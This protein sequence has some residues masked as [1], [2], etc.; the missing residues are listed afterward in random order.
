MC[1]LVVNQTLGVKSKK[2]HNTVQE[3]GGEKETQKSRVMHR[4]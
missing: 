4:E 1:N 3:K 2:I